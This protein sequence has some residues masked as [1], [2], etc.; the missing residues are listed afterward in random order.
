MKTKTADEV[1]RLLHS[2]HKEQ[3]NFRDELR[4][5]NERLTSIEKSVRV[6]VIRREMQDTR[7]E[8]QPDELA[9]INYV[10][11]N[12]GQNKNK[13]IEVF[14]KGGYNGITRSRKITLERINELEKEYDIF[15][16]QTGPEHRQRQC[17]YINDQS[18]LLDLESIM[19]EFRETVVAAIEAYPTKWSAIDEIDKNSEKMSKALLYYSAIFASY[20]QFVSMIILHAMFD[21]PNIAKNPT[22]LKRAYQILFSKLIEILQAVKDSFEKIHVSCR[23]NL[24]HTSWTMHPGIM[25][26]GVIIAQDQSI[27]PHLEKLFNVAWKV[28]RDHFPYAQIFF[29]PAYNDNYVGDKTVLGSEWRKTKDVPESWKKPLEEWLERQKSQQQQNSDQKGVPNSMPIRSVIVEEK[30]DE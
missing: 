13:I 6:D 12:P 3:L 2:V 9:L 27:L 7:A 18:F 23:G 4:K 1:T 15:K 30:I 20:Q 22:T 29:D 11:D 5:V 19:R 8:F 24:A 26:S 21:W 10:R 14:E 16:L 17:V 28:S 25:Y